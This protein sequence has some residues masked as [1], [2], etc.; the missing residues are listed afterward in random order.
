MLVSSQ[1]CIVNPSKI[2]LWIQ[3]TTIINTGKYNLM[4]LVLSSV[5]QMNK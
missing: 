2:Y 5:I 1:S 4:S 3:D